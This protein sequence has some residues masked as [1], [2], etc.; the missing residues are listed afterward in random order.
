MVEGALG[1]ELL[2]TDGMV[3]EKITLSSQIV[4]AARIMPLTRIVNVWLPRYERPMVASGLTSVLGILIRE[5]PI[6]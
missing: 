2:L 5:H 6:S 3:G 4:F 1:I